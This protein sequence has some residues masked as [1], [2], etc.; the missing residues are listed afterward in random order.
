MLTQLDRRHIGKSIYTKMNRIFL[1]EVA[2]VWSGILKKIIAKKVLDVC[3]WPALFYG[4]HFNEKGPHLL[5]GK[6]PTKR[7]L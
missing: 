5:P 6:P 3:D 1:Q 2:H 7:K 4:S